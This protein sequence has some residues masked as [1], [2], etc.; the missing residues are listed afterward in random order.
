MNPNITTAIRGLIRDGQAAVRAA[1]ERGT[2]ETV[3]GLD[4][5]L[6]AFPV[7]DMDDKANRILTGALNAVS[8]ARGAEEWTLMDNVARTVAALINEPDGATLEHPA[9]RAVGILAFQ[10]SLNHDHKEGPVA[11]AWDRGWMAGLEAL[12]KVT[13]LIYGEADGRELEKALGVFLDAVRRAIPYAALFETRR[14]LVEVA[15]TYGLFSVGMRQPLIRWEWARVIGGA[16]FLFEVT[17]PG[18]PHPYGSLAVRRVAPDGTHSPVR[19]FPLGPD[20]DDQ[21]AEIRYRI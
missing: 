21:R 1:E 14:V 7:L 9:V 3:E 16:V 13:G 2:P 19:Y 15:R 18:Q 5:A 8:E 20:E 12:R 6:C 17:P 11:A 4:K 10:C